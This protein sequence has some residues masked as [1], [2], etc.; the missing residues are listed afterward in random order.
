MYA[1]TV[2]VQIPNGSE[3]VLSVVSPRHEATVTG[4]PSG[5]EQTA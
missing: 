4:S 1:H 2:I 3:A 5:V